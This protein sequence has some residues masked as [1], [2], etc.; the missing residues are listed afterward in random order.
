M[1]RAQLES[2]LRAA[3]GARMRGELDA[4]VATFAPDAVFRLAGSPQA[5]PIA[6]R[7][8]GTESV[9]AHM[10]RLIDAVAFDEHEIVSILVDGSRVGVHARVKLRARASGETA[11]TE[12]FDLIEFRDG[13]IASFTEFC[14]T[15]L[16][17][18]MLGA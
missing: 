10:G 11:T 2:S 7:A 16:A 9:R 12:L 18:R 17:A 4:V 3:Y 5:S 14:D 13:K 1:E 8:A 15:A 6:L